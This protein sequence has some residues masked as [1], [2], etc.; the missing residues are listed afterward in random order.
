MLPRRP[1][2]VST[3]ADPRLRV[4][5]Q[6]CTR[7]LRASGRCAAQT[8][9]CSWPTP[10]A[11][12]AASPSSRM[13]GAWMQ[14]T[15]APRRLSLRHLVPVCPCHCSPPYIH[16][17]PVHALAAALVNRVCN[18]AD[19]VP[20]RTVH[21]PVVIALGASATPLFTTDQEGG[22]ETRK[23]TIEYQTRDI[24]TSRVFTASWRTHHLC[25]SF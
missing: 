19:V 24:H 5:L 20:P 11:R 4:C 2:T 8:T 12:S 10:C 9:R 6:V 13:P 1:V 18:G 17:Y 3:C 15:L 25:R 16:L 7:A 14:C 21:Q 22:G 23:S